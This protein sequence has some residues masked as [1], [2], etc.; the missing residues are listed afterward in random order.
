MKI[1][2]KKALEASKKLSKLSPD[3]RKKYSKIAVGV[4]SVGIL[5]GV[6]GVMKKSGI[7]FGGIVIDRTF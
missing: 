6:A 2:N 1:Y 5:I 3:K 4:S 7:P